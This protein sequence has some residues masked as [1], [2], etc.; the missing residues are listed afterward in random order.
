MEALEKLRKSAKKLKN[1][2]ATR[3]CV[4]R[5]QMVEKM[6]ERMNR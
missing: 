3:L 1:E 4:F 2:Y 6:T 5:E